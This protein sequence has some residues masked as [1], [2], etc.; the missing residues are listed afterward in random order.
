ML[1]H[2]VQDGRDEGRR[3]ERAHAQRRRHQVGEVRLEV[4]DVVLL[5]EGDNRA[6]HG[7]R[8][9]LVD[10]V[11]LPRLHRRVEQLL[12]VGDLERL[13]DALLDLALVV[14]LRHRGRALRHRLHLRKALR[15]AEDVR[16]A[17]RHHVERAF[18]VGARGQLLADLGVRVLV[19]EVHGVEAVQDAQQ[20][21]HGVVQARMDGAEHDHALLDL[22]ERRADRRVRVAIGHVVNGRADDALARVDQE[23]KQLEQNRGRWV[24]RQRHDQLADVVRSHAA[25]DLHHLRRLDLEALAALAAALELE[26]RLAVADVRAVEQGAQGA[27]R[28]GR[29]T[30]DHVRQADGVRAA[31][32]HER[33]LDEPLQLFLRFVDLVPVAVDAQHLAARLVD[34]DDVR[35]RLIALNGSDGV[36]LEDRA[37]PVFVV[38]SLF[39][40]FD[41]VV[42]LLGDAVVRLHADRPEVNVAVHAALDAALVVHGRQV[43][44]VRLALRRVEVRRGK[45]QVQIVDGDE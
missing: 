18:E 9:V 40:A 22:G 10:G 11:L 5:G 41:L 1:L 42:R 28:R 31:P 38:G 2:V 20:L 26:H 6:A 27:R 15:L 7:R 17:D 14:Q 33:E 29:Q 45:R 21:G 37:Q 36:H 3:D 34:A 4:G 35:Q 43:L 19:V 25:L 32:R 12:G 23:A 13:E 30:A 24:V 44:H 16:V 8:H 39:A